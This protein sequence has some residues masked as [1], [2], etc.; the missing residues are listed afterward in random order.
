MNLRTIRSMRV[1]GRLRPGTTVLRSQTVMA[2]LAEAEAETHPESNRGWHIKVMPLKEHGQA[3]S[4]MAVLLL[5][6]AVSCL[7][8]IACANIAH[9]LTARSGIRQG[10]M[11]IRLALGASRVRLV[12]QLVIESSVLAVSGGVLA[13]AVAAA[14]LWLLRHWGAVL[15]PPPV[16]NELL[17]MRATILDPAVILFSVLACMAALLMFGVLP[18][19]LITRVPLN[20]VL[21][22]STSM[23]STRRIKFSH[24]LVGLEAAVV[25]VLL[26]HSGLLVR[27][28]VK[29]TS[30][31][32]GIDKNNRLIFDIELPRRTATA[33]PLTQAEVYLR[34]QRRAAWL[35]DLEQ[36]LQ[37]LAEIQA[38]GA[39][40][41]FS[42]HDRRRWLGGHGR[43][44]TVAS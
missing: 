11:A 36:R 21:Q 6:A 12:A 37:S 29:L 22:G 18:S 32:V 4:R 19:F 9:L 35:E 16:F 3:Q 43:W 14:I 30:V 41:S 1:V 25:V 20:K 27:S 38:V 23:R 8:F 39:S 24:L 34:S 15:L 40:N 13:W 44:Q 33:G 10:E 42:A 5:W 7:L 2:T 28:F 31:P 17:R 26:I